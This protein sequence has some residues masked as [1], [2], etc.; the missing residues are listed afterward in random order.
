MI[1]PTRNSEAGSARVGRARIAYSGAAWGRDNLEQF[2][3]EIS[4][5]GYCGIEAS[6]KVAAYHYDKIYG[7]KDILHDRGLRLVSLHGHLALDD[8]LKQD[9]EVS[10]N[11]MIAEFIK[12]C[13]GDIL[14]FGG[15][16]KSPLVPSRVEGEGKSDDDLRRLTEACNEIGDYCRMLGVKACY[17]P[18][19]GTPV[20]NAEDIDRFLEATEPS[21]IYLCPDTAHLVRAGADP[22]DVFRR[23]ADRIAYVHFKDVR[24]GDNGEGQFVFPELGRGNVDFPAVLNVLRETG[25]QGWIT[26]DIDKGPVPPK[27]SAEICKRY[28]EDV[29]GL[30]LSRAG[31]PLEVEKAP[32][33]VK[34]AMP[35]PIQ[36]EPESV[37]T[38]R[39]ALQAESEIAE[40]PSGRPPAEAPQEK[41]EPVAAQQEASQEFGAGIEP[42]VPKEEEA[43]PAPEI[44]RQGTPVV[45]TEQ[46]EQHPHEPTEETRPEPEQ[47]QEHPGKEKPP[48]DDQQ[49]DFR[50]D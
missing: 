34:Q 31:F 5:T 16:L 10:Y 17:H 26:V 30:S 47:Q 33:E 44:A 36:A 15:G 39:A 42:A 40:G 35:E 48:G 25:Y 6:G 23:H 13:G 24:V 22:V 20:E 27:E 50:E 8:P 41:E 46:Q 14:V 29:L 7:F 28:I 3:D 4:E 38:L 11:K 49:V 32:P 21:L 19:I 37:R 12:F 9:D 43:A 18:H 45:Y 1:Q 2:L